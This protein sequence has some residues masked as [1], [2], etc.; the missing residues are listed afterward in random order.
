MATKFHGAGIDYDSKYTGAATDKP[1]ESKS[2]SVA[3]VGGEPFY[4][5]PQSEYLE[6]LKWKGSKA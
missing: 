6:F 4:M 1:N 3:N 2:F 5:V